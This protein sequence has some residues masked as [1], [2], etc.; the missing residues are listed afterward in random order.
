MNPEEIEKAKLEEEARLEAEKAND[1]LIKLQEENARLQE[2]RDN[3]KKVALQRKGK[4]PGDTDFF[5]DTDDGELSVAEQVKLALLEREIEKTRE[6]EKAEIERIRKENSE[7]RLAIK[8]RPGSS[9]GGDSG[10]SSDVKDNV[11]SVEQI[12]VLEAKA[13]RLGADPEKFIQN[14]KLNLMKKG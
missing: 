1:P 12:K 10:S 11:F 3:Y 8:N 14:A 6:A 13:K 7:L 5:K 4:L 2:E 9:I